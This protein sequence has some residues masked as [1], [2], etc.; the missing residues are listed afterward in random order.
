MPNPELRDLSEFRFSPELSSGLEFA[1]ASYLSPF[2]KISVSWRRYGD[3]FKLKVDSP[4]EIHGS[5]LLP[6]GF[7]FDG[8]GREK[9]L[10][11]GEYV[12]IKE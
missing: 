12:A 2:G 1:E 11:T 5:I 10:S 3:K 8:G 9:A 7:S 4:S 6:C